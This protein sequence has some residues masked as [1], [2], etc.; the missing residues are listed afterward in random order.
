MDSFAYQSNF[1]GILLFLHKNHWIMIKDNF[2]V[3]I[4]NLLQQNSRLSFVQIGKEI[5]LSPTA[6]ADRMKRL[7]EDGIILKNYTLIDHKKVGYSLSAF[8]SIKF[9]SGKL[10]QFQKSINKFP[11]IVECHRITG[12][13]CLIMKVHLK[14]STHLEEII[15]RLVLYGDPS[16]SVI[17][18]SWDISNNLPISLTRT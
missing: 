8:I 13:D 2:D 1:K 6:V 10:M 4:L 9:H 16:T 5:G 3:E 15:D 12:N 11:E 17:L 14:D 7:E 18:S